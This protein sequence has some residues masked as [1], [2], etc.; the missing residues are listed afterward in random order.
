MKT[1]EEIEDRISIWKVVIGYSESKD[2]LSEVESE[3]LALCRGK[4]ESLEWVLGD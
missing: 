4:L 1:R 2:N 3:E